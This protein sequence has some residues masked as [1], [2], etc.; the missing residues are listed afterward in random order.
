MAR[1]SSATNPRD[2]R[3]G[4]ISESVGGI[5]RSFG[6][7]LA[8]SLLLAPA[9]IAAARQQVQGEELAVLTDAPMVPPPITRDHPTKMIVRLETHEVTS[10]LSD[11][12]EYTFWTFGGHVPGKFIRVRVG[13][14]VEFHLGNDPQSRFPHNI[15]LHGVTGPGG[16]AA[17]SMT[18]PGQT[19]VLASKL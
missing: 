6:I 4:S 12:V 13:D 18:A 3:D 16:G 15:D 17:A 8:A 10:R 5:M 14:Y 19:S 9:S 1:Y 11:G 2:P 7:L